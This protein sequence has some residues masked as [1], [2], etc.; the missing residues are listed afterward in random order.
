MS[1]EKVVPTT[2]QS[3]PIAAKI[4][5]KS[6][7]PPRK[8]ATVCSEQ[9]KAT[10]KTCSYKT[11]PTGMIEKENS[12]VVQ[13]NCI[14]QAIKKISFDRR[15]SGK[16]LSNIKSSSL[17]RISLSL[18]VEISLIKTILDFTQCQVTEEQPVE[19]T[20]SL[21]PEVEEKPITEVLD[22][23]MRE[24]VKQDSLT[25]ELICPMLRMV[26]IFSKSL[27]STL[28]RDFLEK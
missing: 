23:A 18:L 19:T 17:E 12:S 21:V 7:K 1:S 4:H 9:C 13:R 3:S 22:F 25:D 5:T 27:A 14:S 20:E 10:S 6:V 28:T 15:P 2:A 8:Q 24:I 16:K 11:V 26:F